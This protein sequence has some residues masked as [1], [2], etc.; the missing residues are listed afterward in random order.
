MRKDNQHCAMA[1]MLVLRDFD[2]RRHAANLLADRPSGSTTRG[3][4]PVGSPQVIR[5][6]GGSR[7]LATRNPLSSKKVNRNVAVADRSSFV[8]RVAASTFRESR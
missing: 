1:Y 3:R 6:P 7:R 2:C 8:R 4:E 5:Q